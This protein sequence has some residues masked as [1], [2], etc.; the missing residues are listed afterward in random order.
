MPG[1]IGKYFIMCMASAVLPSASSSVLSYVNL[2][3][4]L[5]YPT[6]KLQLCKVGQNK[7]DMKRKGFL[8][9]RYWI[10]FIDLHSV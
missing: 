6:E 5:K 10:I 1:F 2:F 3:S 4:C 9:G 8:N 7:K